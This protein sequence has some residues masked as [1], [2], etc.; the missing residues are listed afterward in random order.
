MARYTVINEL[1]SIEFHDSVL[2]AV[3]IHDGNLYMVFSDAIIIGQSFPEK[4]DRN[5]CSVNDGEDRYACPHLAVAFQ[6]FQT[7][8]IIKCGFLTQDH[9][10]NII[11]QCPS[12]TLSADEYDV[13]WGLVLAEKDIQ[14]NGLSYDKATGTSTLCI[15]LNHGTDC[16][17]VTLS[18]ET[19]IVEFEEFGK[20]AWYLDSKW[21]KYSQE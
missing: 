15:F 21:R 10:G 13:F 6:S 9:K 20:E 14:V 4:K 1:Q 12:L 17:E 11:D 2:Q 16:Y 18:A 19:S 5:R 3:S 7:R 8:S